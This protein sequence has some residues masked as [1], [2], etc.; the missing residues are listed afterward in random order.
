MD[1]VNDAAVY[2][3]AHK[4]PALLAVSVHS[5]HY[6]GYFLPLGYVD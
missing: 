5:L 6:Y 2:L 4:G 1:V 3:L